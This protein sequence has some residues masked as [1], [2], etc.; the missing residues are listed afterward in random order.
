MNKNL[1][2]S[3]MM[4]AAAFLFATGGLVLKWV[5]WNPLAINGARSFF[6]AITLLLFLVITKH[7]VAWNKTVFLGAVSYVLMTTLF[8][9]S[10][11]LT[12]AAN[13]I[14]LQYT[15]PVWIILISAVVFHK[16][17]NRLEIIT[18][19]LVL[20]GIGCFFAGSL[21][22]GGIAGDITAVVS[23]LFYAILFYINSMPG[24]DAIS[25]VF[26]GQIISTV[27]LGPLSFSQ[28]W[29]WSVFGS[30]VWLGAFQV[31]LAYIFFSLATSRI[32]P[33]QASLITGFEPILNPILV[34]VFW[35]E[36]IGPL[37]LAGAA[38]VIGSIL[39][40]S[41]IQNKTDEKDQTSPAA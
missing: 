28:T 37:E 2:G 1:A 3:L 15:C 38:I 14:V 6:G 10:N 30:I 29:N 19:A 7:K 9:V 16:K 18:V 11:K 22:S 24:G 13:A 41:V 12:S 20:V 27:V 39:V 40:Y 36:T 31:G 26:I 25:S 33:L 32:P 4:A 17:P 21:S 23:G 35:H 5:D 8:V 34:A